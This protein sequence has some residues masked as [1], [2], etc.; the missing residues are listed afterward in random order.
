MVVKPV[1]AAVVTDYSNYYSTQMRKLSLSVIGLYCTFLSAYSQGFKQPDTLYDPKPLRLDEINLVSSYYVQNGN[2]S[3]V[4]GGM[5]NE[6]VVDLANGL[7]LKFVGWDLSGHKHSLGL[8]MG[9]DHHTAA[10]SAWVSKTGASSTKGT[11]IY[12]AFNYTV[13]NVKGNSV[14]FGAYYS[15]EYNYKSFGLD[16]HTTQK[17]SSNSELNGKFSAFFDK[18]KMIYPSEL[19]PTKD[20][21]T[22]TTTYTTAS[23]REIGLGGDDEG[24]N[25]IPSSPRNTFTGSLSF[26][27]VINTRLQASVMVDLVGQQGYLGLPFHR[28]YFTDGSVHVE[29]LPS[30]R[31]KLPIGFRLNYFMGDHIILRSYYRYYMDNWGLK[32]HTA[33][34]EVSVKLSPFFSV[35]PFYRYYTQTAV[36]YFSP[37][38]MHAEDTKNP[39]Y[40]SN[41][42]LSALTSQFM[43]AGFHLAPPKGILNKHFSALEMRYGHYLQ[44]TDLTANVISAAFTFK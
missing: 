27:Q 38:G 39:Y 30:S 16:I 31:L 5:G 17:L 21:P 6:H 15:T 13:E 32:A 43:G 36:K 14:G 23:G 33:D 37:Y 10:S 7:E 35:S 4:L 20:T 22:G 18:V 42:S 34:M 40:T 2:H 44:S 26:S 8:E 12:P 24:E 41:Y 19:I 1:V 29:N 9:F 28:V 25:K 3:A 11:R